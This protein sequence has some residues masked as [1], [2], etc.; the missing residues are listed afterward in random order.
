MSDT[1]QGGASEGNAEDDA[2]MGDQGGAAGFQ[3]CCRA[4]S[5]WLV[6][7]DK[8]RGSKVQGFDT[9]LPK[10]L[11]SALRTPNFAL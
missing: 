4:S 6:S 2:L 5:L 10:S 7:M 9:C 1:S 8:T 11:Y 3:L